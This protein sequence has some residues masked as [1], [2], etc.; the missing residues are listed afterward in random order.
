M[1]TPME[2]LTV[3]VFHQDKD[4]FLED[5]QVLGVVHISVSLPE[6]L[7][8]PVKELQEKI[9]RCRNFLKAAGK[10]RDVKGNPPK[11]I[12]VFDRV[13]NWE[14]RTERLEAVEERLEFLE[15]QLSAIAPW[16]DFDLSRLRALKDS[17]VTVRFFISPAKHFPEC[18][19]EECVFSEVS[20]DNTYVYFVIM[21]WTKA[22]CRPD[23]EEFFYPD[24]S[25]QEIETELNQQRDEA[26]KLREEIRESLVFPE[27]VKDLL[28]RFETELAYVSISRNLTGTVENTVYIVQ[29]W[30]PRRLKAKAADFFETRGVYYY[31]SSPRPDEA[32]PVLLQNNWFSRLFE[33][34]TRMFSLPNYREM[35]LTGFFAPFFTLFF[36]FC[37]GDAGYGIIIFLAA[38]IAR[39]RIAAEQRPLALLGM[40]LGASTFAFGL[41]SGSLLGIQLVDQEAVPWLRKIVLFDQDQ[42]FGVALIL[43]V[44]Q[45]LFGMLLK[46]INRIRQYGFTAG[47]S[48]FGWILILLG[49]LGMGAGMWGQEPPFFSSWLAWS[50]V[51]LVLLFNDL[52][53]NIFIRIGKGLWEL[54]GITGLFGDIL[55][56]IRLFALGISSSI[57]GIV[58]ND[59]AL[60]LRDVPY[61][62]FGLTFLFLIIGHTGNLLL[63]SLSSFV[64]PL[65][66]TFV[67]FYKHA[68]F[69]GG[70]RPYTPFRRHGEQGLTK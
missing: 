17:G 67:E 7:P 35:D 18:I 43:G 51:A 14:S 1:I 30:L 5:L 31:F 53:A 13:R 54:Y 66:L 24:S 27:G 40:I 25:K 10:E 37:L 62:G 63:S 64:H 48:S 29:G 11:E 33:P 2:K 42:L 59:I 28:N 36:G 49:L 26:G 46:M 57:L 60:Q 39:S 52:R 20:R 68:G 16:G 47:L 70:G 22:T 21:E 44:V 45:V 9:S 23:C 65:R 6:T 61:V 15:K 34:I 32:V 3:L 8:A 41:I 19:P 38:L 55:S 58:V 4:R 69:E 12:D 50:G 56:Y